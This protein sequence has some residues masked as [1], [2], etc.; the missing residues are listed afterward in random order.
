MLCYA[1]CCCAAVV[2]L[3]LLLSR[4]VEVGKCLLWRNKYL[5]RLGTV[6]LVLTYLPSLLV[7]QHR[8]QQQS[9]RVSTYLHTTAAASAEQ[10]RAAP[11]TAERKQKLKL[12]AE[13]GGDQQSRGI[14]WS[15]AFLYKILGTVTFVWGVWEEEKSWKQSI[16]VVLFW[17]V[18]LS[19]P[20]CHWFS[21]SS[22]TNKRR[23]QA[24]TIERNFNPPFNDDTCNY[25]SFSDFMHFFHC[26]CI[27][28]Q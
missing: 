2:P 8:E 15:V 10:Q 24:L 12:T 9:S 1:I 16:I 19:S 7:G 28:A 21:S 5:L 4:L 13:R 26:N 18:N 14:G 3:L 17:T 23:R 27:Q 25:E 11:H 20:F 6:L 22:W